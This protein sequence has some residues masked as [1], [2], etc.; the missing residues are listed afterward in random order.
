MKLYQILLLVIVL[1][2]V[3]EGHNIRTKVNT[4]SGSGSGSGSGCLK[5]G[6]HY[7]T[8]GENIHN[9]KKCGSGSG[10]GSG[11]GSF[12]EIQRSKSN[13][14]SVWDYYDGDIEG[15]P[16][17]ENEKC[18]KKMFESVFGHADHAKFNCATTNPFCD[19]LKLCTESMTF[20]AKGDTITIQCTSHANSYTTESS[21]KKRRLLGMSSGGSCLNGGDK[22][23]FA[24]GVRRRR[25]RR[26]LLTR[27]QGGC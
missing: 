12:L 16:E 6:F 10:S 5:P 14:E 9:V 27:S 21:T 7:A 23:N 2:S 20:T 25:R 11:P 15:G 24:N 26:R 8:K 19:C 13:L 17:D 18:H 3:V 1:V 4:K 22:C